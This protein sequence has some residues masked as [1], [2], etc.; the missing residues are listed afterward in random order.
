MGNPT[1]RQDPE[2]EALR[3][4]LRQR[5]YELE[6]LKETA[7][8]VGRERDPA[9]VLQLIADRA[10]EIIQAETVLVPVLNAERTHYTYEAGSGEYAQEAVGES[11]PIDQG[12][13]GWV[14]R[15]KK[16]WWR[17]VLDELDEN[18]RT[19]WEARAGTVLMVPLI[20]KGT[21]LGGLAGLR[22]LDGEDF[23]RADLNLLSL[24]ASQVVVALENALAFEKLEHARQDAERYQQQL[25]QLNEALVTANRE[26][27]YLSLYDELTGL[28]NRTLFR[29]RIQQGLT[30][31]GVIAQPLAIL[32]LDLDQFKEVNDTFGHEFGDRLLKL[33]S[34]RFGEITRYSDTVGRLGGD[35]FGLLLPNA[36]EAKAAEIAGKLLRSL[37]SS[38]ELEGHSLSMTASIGI[39]VYPDHGRDMTTLLRHA[40][41]AMYQAKTS[42]QSLAVYDA[43]DDSYSPQQLILLGDLR[44]ALNEQQFRLEYQPKLDIRSG[45]LVG[46]EALAR[47]PQPERGL[48]SPT[49]FVHSLEQSR[50]IS[51]FNQWALSTAVEQAA[52]WR[53]QGYDFAVSVNLSVHSLLNPAFPDELE[54]LLDKWGLEGRLML[55][56][57]E[58][59]FLSDYGRLSQTLLRLQRRGVSF[60]IDDFGTGH[61]SLSRL[62]RLPVSELKIDRSFVIEM[63]HNPDDLVI[64]HSTIDLAHNLGLSVVAEGVENARVLNRLKALGCDIAQGFHFGHAMPP[65][66]L[67]AKIRHCGW[68]EEGDPC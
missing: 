52:R 14:W 25:Q 22:K 13:C 6:L 39:A 40:D 34:E 56:I 20:G 53:D 45:R 15:N 35:E 21:F 68:L 46:V 28:P 31:A 5:E 64:V 37:D 38:F 26:L 63:E 3:N 59:L 49:A 47:W 29:D 27:E 54:T 44:R 17:G 67:E 50:L 23:T 66:E 12:I 18:E 16:P 57:T 33:V 30:V 9:L 7:L 51:T 42:K 65:D 43:S 8:A 55:E 4:S 10:R 32:L 58:N 11:L 1:R 19:H 41:M 48:I 36:D 62:K 60:S 24:F 2:T 61:S